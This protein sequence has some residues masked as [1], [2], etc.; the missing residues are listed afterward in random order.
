MRPGSRAEAAS[1]AWGVFRVLAVLVLLTLGMAG[2]ETLRELRQALPFGAGGPYDLVI[3]GGTVVDGTG[4]PPRRAD[5]GVLDGRVARVSERSLRRARAARVIDATGKVVAPGF[6][7]VHAHLDSLLAYPDAESLVRQGVTTALGGHDGAAPLPLFIYLDSL[8]RAGTGPNVAF[9]AGHASIRERV[10]GDARRPAD[11]REIEAMR[12]LVAQAMGD[13][14][15]GLSAALD[16]SPLAS[17]NA[18]ELVALAEVASDSGGFYAAR[19]RD[20]GAGLIAAVAEVLEVGRRA[21]ID[22][23]LSRHMALGAPM[24][25]A[26]RITLAM[27]DSARAA[28][29]E[30]WQD[31]FPYTATTGPIS[32]LV[33]AWALEGGTDAFLLRTRQPAFRDSIVE[34]IMRGIVDGPGGNDLSRVRLVRVPWSPELEGRTLREWALE[35]FVE[36]VPEAGA[37]LVIEAIRRGGAHAVFGSLDEEDVRRVLAHPR[38]MIATDGGPATDTAHPHPR[39]YGAFPHAL[40]TYV[41]QDSLLSLAEAIRKMTWLPARVIG[42][43]DRGRLAEGY[44]GDI[45]VLDP[46]RVRD[47]ATYLDPRQHPAGIDWVVVNGTVA[48][49]DGMWLGRRSGQ[50]L[51]RP[52]DWS[53]GDRRGWRRGER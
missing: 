1:P 51:R 34:G 13:G 20:D 22:V 9:L 50:V 10:M 35:R 3:T 44:R 31:A 41:R 4:A 52:H 7:D 47:T 25:G 11:L 6:I 2:C 38:T 48:V 5:V 14:A 46:A 42:L 18:I 53:L 15:W 8:A 39:L 29:R 36:P 30:V 32:E 21:L 24:W 27:A 16:R 17:A 28:G 49:A 45:V 26:T 19:L 37:E 40:A 43:R 33:P 23:V 12:R